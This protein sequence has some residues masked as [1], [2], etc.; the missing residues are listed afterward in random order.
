MTF[1]VVT[2]E[3]V[4]VEPGTY[5]LGDP[6]YAVHDDDWDE[7]LYTSKFFERPVGTTNNGTEV[8]AFRTI[9]GDGVYRDQYGN[10]YP[11]DAGVIGLTPVD[12]F[13]DPRLDGLGQV[14]V[15]TGPITAEDR[16]GVLWFGEYTINTDCEEEDE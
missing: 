9:Y 14:I 8:L 7:V 10:D 3:T 13:W 4:I 6:C 11:V 5:F 1:Q 2:N 12:D 15:L 16:T